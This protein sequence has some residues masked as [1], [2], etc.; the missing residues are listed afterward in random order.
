[1]ATS[2]PPGSSCPIGWQPSALAPVFYGYREYTAAEGAPLTVRVYYP[3]LDDSPAGAAPLLGCGRYPLILFCHGSCPGEPLQYQKWIELPA[4]LARAG[5]VVA[6]PQVPDIDRLP[7]EVPATQEA[8]RK[9]LDWMRE[10][11]E[12]RDTLLPP[13]ATGLAG[14]S[15]GALHA[16]IL[17]TT[18][19][20]L[21][22]V[23]LS[24]VWEE[25]SDPFPIRQ[26]AWARLFTW[27]TN[28]MSENSA[29]L[30][31]QY[32]NPFRSRS[33]GCCSPTPTTS[34]TST[35]PSSP[36]IRSAV[37]ARSSV[38]TPPTPR[39]CSSPVTCNRR[40]GPTWPREFP[41]R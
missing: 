29:D 21:A 34:T 33:T 8:L 28:T 14:H 3:S 18:R 30:P 36:A 11:W 1:M 41:T 10:G 24:G 26:G 38:R 23:S 17:A 19:P 20:V 32:W 35:R 40:T 39:R 4:Q 5:Y 27:G 22:V 15:Y 7:I 16:G 2:L 6:V 13:P 12:N 31:P 37:R 25:L 9:L